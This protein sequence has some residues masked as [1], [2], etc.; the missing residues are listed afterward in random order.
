MDATGKSHE[1]YPRSNVYENPLA[2]QKPNELLPD[3]DESTTYLEKM[4][5]HDPRTGNIQLTP[6]PQTSM[7]TRTNIGPLD[8]QDNF[9]ARSAGD[10]PEKTYQN[11]LYEEEY[12]QAHRYK[13][14]KEGFGNAKNNREYDLPYKVEER[15]AKQTSSQMSPYFDSPAYRQ[16]SSN[17]D[18]PVEEEFEL[19]YNPENASTTGN[20]LFTPMKF[21]EKYKSSGNPRAD[22]PVI[23]F[24]DQ[25]SQERASLNMKGS[26]SSAL[27]EDIMPKKYLPEEIKARFHENNPRSPSSNNEE[28]VAQ[29]NQ[30]LSNCSSTIDREISENAQKLASSLYQKLA[31]KISRPAGRISIDDDTRPSRKNPVALD[32]RKGS[33]AAEQSQR[34]SISRTPNRV[35]PY[36][37]F[38]NYKV[39]ISQ[40]RSSPRSD[41]PTEVEAAHQGKQK[42]LDLLQAQRASFTLPN[43]DQRDLTPRSNR[44]NTSRGTPR[45]STYR[46]NESIRV[47][48]GIYYL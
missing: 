34:Q 18:R 22:E 46:S 7:S 12:Q 19:R 29:L 36:E 41:Q 37:P 4:Q 13:G 5:M 11:T 25:Q 27:R 38:E 45:D 6:N 9:L 33:A 26:E 43:K 24:R 20:Q 48:D 35:V 14:A 16:P 31:N 42:E 47:Q 40:R 30:P 10:M 1:N 17:Q 28:G 3:Y 8:R 44:S 2:R 21:D 15:E 39:D 23:T 32:I